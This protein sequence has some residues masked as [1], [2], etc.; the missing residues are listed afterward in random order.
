MYSAFRSC[1]RGVAA[2]VWIVSQRAERVARILRFEVD[3]AV[4]ALRA[5]NLKGE[6]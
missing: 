3:H 4:V 5:Y 6:P 1:S 2:D